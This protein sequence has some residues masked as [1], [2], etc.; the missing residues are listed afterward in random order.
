MFDWSL[1]ENH[2]IAILK[3]DHDTIK[4][5]LDDF[6]KARTSADKEKIIAKAIME[7]Q[8]HSI[9]EEEIFYSAVR[10][11]IGSQIM[12]EADD[13]HQAVRVLIAE[14]LRT[15]NHNGQR[16][17]KFTVVAERIRHHIKE[18]E[19]E[20]L[21]KAKGLDIDFL[22]LGQ[23]LLDRKKELLRDGIP[24]D[25]EY[26]IAIS[27]GKTDSSAAKNRRGQEGRVEGRPQVQPRP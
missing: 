11:H 6:E 17:A 8:I 25:D 16:E 2:A 3:K 23:R 15:G 10:V 21:P 9:L 13:E 24:P 27:N 4:G 22:A 12:N 5:L 20:M 7:Q 1:P 18:E 26:P 19:T 14:L